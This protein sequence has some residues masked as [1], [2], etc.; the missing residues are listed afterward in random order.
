MVTH[1]DE[2][3][4]VPLAANHT[5]YNF[6]KL[7]RRF[8][9]NDYCV[10]VVDTAAF[11][12]CFSR[13]MP[14]YIIPTVD[15]WQ[16][17]RKEAIQKFLDPNGNGVPEMPVVSFEL[18]SRKKWFGL[19]QDVVEGVISFTNGRHRSRY[20]QFSGAKCFPVQINISS[21]EELR[22]YCGCSCCN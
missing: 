13:E 6:V 3:W 12:E 22:K 8:D 19:L 9:R 2:I 14:G 5:P 10:V 16:L 18:S 7:K 4:T 15:R 21:A 17:D 20:L 1:T 11:M